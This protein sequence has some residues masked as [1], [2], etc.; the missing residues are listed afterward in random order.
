MKNIRSIL[1]NTHKKIYYKKIFYYFQNFF[2]TPTQHFDAAQMGSIS[3]DWHFSIVI[4]L[5]IVLLLA[6]SCLSDM[7][8]M[9]MTAFTSNFHQ[10]L[11]QLSRRPTRPS[12]GRH[13]GPSSIS[14]IYI[15]FERELK[16]DSDDYFISALRSIEKKL[17]TK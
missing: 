9:G 12:R 13:R 14:L 1:K 5:E 11:L 16:T 6:L 4:S 2:S 7:L 8:E 17:S 3:I 15:S 10:V